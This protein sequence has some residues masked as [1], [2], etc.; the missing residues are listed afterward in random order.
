[1]VEEYLSQLTERVET[2]LAKGIRP[3]NIDRCESVSPDLDLVQFRKHWM[4][5]Q[6]RRFAAGFA[7][8][9]C[10][11]A[12]D[13]DDRT[14]AFVVALEL[15]REY[16]ILELKRRFEAYRKEHPLFQCCRKLWIL[17]REGELID[18]WSVKHLYPSRLVSA[19]GGWGRI[20]EFLPPDL[21][22]WAIAEFTGLSMYVRLDP[23]YGSTVK[24]QDDLE[25]AGVRPARGGWW[26][27]LNLRN[28]QAEG[29]HYVLQPFEE[30]DPNLHW[31]YAD[32]HWYGVRSLEVHAVRDNG[33]N[34]SMMLEELVEERE[35]RMLGRC[36]HLDTDDGPGTDA[37]SA[38]L[39]HIDLA[40]N[41][42]TGES[43]K[44]R[45]SQQLA[46]GRVVDAS[47]RTH[48]LRVEGAAFGTIAEFARQFFKSRTLLSEWSSDQLG[49]DVVLLADDE[50]R[51]GDKT[52]K[53]AT[54]L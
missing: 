10:F 26:T 21:L 54:T 27:K 5:D 35:G 53:S 43:V 34:L 13:G 12:M 25:K 7:A 50:N 45:R 40:I 14:A 51:D 15:D 36:I 32:Y 42:Y 29:G 4:S 23:W 24:P 38:R 20:D 2:Y 8:T 6:D 28:R 17:V 48:L 33:G 11:G 37:T 39:N 30:Y 44:L 47:F 16:E 18:A 22:N 31:Q 3:G 49:Q 52:G 41:V 1:M 46:D 19:K 9:G